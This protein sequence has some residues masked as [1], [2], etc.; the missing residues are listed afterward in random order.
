MHFVI[1]KDF[2]HFPAEHNYFSLKVMSTYIALWYINLMKIRIIATF[3]NSNMQFIII[4]LFSR[5]R[6]ISPIL[7][8]KLIQDSFYLFINMPNKICK[9]TIFLSKMKKVYKFLFEYFRKFCW[10]HDQRPTT[11]I[12]ALVL[13]RFFMIQSTYLVVKNNHHKSHFALC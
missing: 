7:R 13:F 4:F 11:T 10:L 6:T 12:I 2:S 3:D 8:F 9:L 1:C 5:I